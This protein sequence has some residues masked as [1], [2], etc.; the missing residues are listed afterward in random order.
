LE[1]KNNWQIFNII[2]QN[3]PILLRRYLPHY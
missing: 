2:E 1:D 3:N